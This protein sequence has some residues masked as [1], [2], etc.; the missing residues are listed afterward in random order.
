M[1][2]Q[3]D[4]VDKCELHI[5]EDKSLDFCAIIALKQ[6][7][8]GPALGGC[9]MQFYPSIEA[10]ITEAK[11]LAHAMSYKAALS[12]L[13]HDGGKAIIMRSSKQ[14]EPHVILKRFAECV[15]TLKGRYITTI[16][17][18]TS[19]EDMSI[20][21]NYTSFVTGYLRENQE[22]DPSESTALGVF[23]G[24]KTAVE[25]LLEREQLNGL[26]VAIQGVGHVGY[27]LARYLHQAGVRL[28]VC[29]IDPER[30]DRCK[31]EFN[32]SVV[33]PE[34]IYSVACDIF[35]P[36]ALGQIINHE[37]IPQFNTKIIAGA[38][39]D[40]L[41]F[42]TL[43]ED[44]AER[45]ILYIP[46]YLIN[47]GGLIHLSLQQNNKTQA[48]IEEHVNEIAERIRQYALMAKQ[49]NKTLVEITERAA[50]SILE[51]NQVCKDN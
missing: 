11:R 4:D 24:I 6:Y 34:K 21:K 43:A 25:I 14:H 35:S 38:A 40:Q 37:T 5:F 26:H 19:Q 41:A 44:L 36:C 9:R 47:A 45:N 48:I 30:A 22:S 15:E 46:D 1:N 27:Y 8:R 49:Q 17:S 33:S 16:D 51:E 39:N 20:I 3:N 23:K 50:R 29:D 13:P 2:L 28:T 31:N 10:A 32:A 18:G 12:E 42:I 7:D